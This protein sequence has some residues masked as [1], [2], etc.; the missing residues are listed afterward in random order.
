MLEPE[1][2]SI[3]DWPSDQQPLLSVVVDTEA[4]FDW[5]RD[6]SRKAVGVTSTRE[7]WRA[8][9]IYE[10]YGVRPTY[11]LDYPVSSQP[12]GYQAIL[13][14]VHDKHAEIGAHLQPWDTPPLTEELSDA[15]SF[16]GNL[17]VE[18]ERA[19]LR[20]LTE[21]IER[22]L[23]C[24]P[25]VY[26]AGRYGVGPAT[27]GLLSEFGYEV[28]VSVLPGTDLSF[29]EGPDFS[30]CG[31]RPYWFG[32]NGGILEV[33]LSI[34]FTGGLARFG[35]GLYK[36]I[37]RPRFRK[38]HLP[39]LVARLHLLDRITLTPEG[40]TFAEQRRLTKTLLKSRHRV[41]SLTYHSPSLAPGNTPYVRT[42]AELD[43]FLYR[44]EQYIDFFM[45][46]IGGRAA[47]PLEV[48]RLA[49]T[50]PRRRALLER[51]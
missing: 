21:T 26:K 8:H 23:G 47:T 10:K 22:N 46:E 41:F 14:L 20:A 45:S 33:P 18:L 42:R 19:K 31:A 40:V 25:R 13:E 35:V 49:E 12:E 50:Q 15:N 9:R 37:A 43:Q 36:F 30:R 38:L 29:Q 27:A 16:P 1:N 28:D 48:K 4:E 5:Y 24:R 17:P 6:S 3:V 32:P 44:I 2:Q 34:G 11:V 7:Q 51:V 39:G